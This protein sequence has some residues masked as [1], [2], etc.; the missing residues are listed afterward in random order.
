MSGMALRDRHTARDHLAGG[1]IGWGN[2]HVVCGCDHAIV[3]RTFSSQAQ[4][5]WQVANS[6]LQ[7]LGRTLRLP[8]RDGLHPDVHGSG[9]IARKEHA[10]RQ[11][12][13]H[14]VVRRVLHQRGLRSIE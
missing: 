8:I 3:E 12:R 10:I 6:G 13:E 1:G 5:V 11:P 2:E 4:R 7:P 14:A 9:A